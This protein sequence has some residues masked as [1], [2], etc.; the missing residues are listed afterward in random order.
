[1]ISNMKGKRGYIGLLIFLLPVHA[2]LQPVPA[3]EE[4]IPYLM[5]FGPVAETSWGDDDFS[6]VFFFYVPKDYDDPLYIRVFDPDVGGD[7]DEVNVEFNTRMK[8]DVYGGNGCWSEEDARSADPVGNYRSGNL[9][10]S[11]I[12]GNDPTYDN[13]WFT[14]GPFSPTQGE[15]SRD[16]D[17]YLFKIIVE[18]VSG[19]DGN[20]YRF[21]LSSLPD[22]NRAIEGANAFTYEY[23]FR[24]W[25]NPNN[26]SHIYPFVDEGT[27]RVL[28]QNFDW[29]DDGEIRTVSV[30][31]NSQLNTVSG[32]D[33]WVESQFQIQEEE[34]GTSL[35]FQFIKQK[36]PGVVRN[37]NV[38]ISIQ[39]QYG[40]FMPFFTA[41]IG[42]IPRYR[43]KIAVQKK[44]D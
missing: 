6:L 30:V 24:L 43:Y 1:M 37:N 19:D 12:F 13:D 3:P 2:F 23:S 7:H 44:E 32:E 35:D 20:M 39:N 14:F 28:Q 26:I 9:L 40:E 33:V 4:N 31:R 8:Y 15:F 27:T 5:T 22:D 18:G 10:A 36:E 17:G 41:P 38:V 16:F 34:I 21:Y 11:R 29:D 42:G 25:N